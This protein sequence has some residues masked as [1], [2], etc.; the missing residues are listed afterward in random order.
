MRRWESRNYY[1][2]STEWSEQEYTDLPLALWQSQRW[3]QRGSWRC[4]W[5]HGPVSRDN[6]RATFH[7]A[8]SKSLSSGPW[9]SWPTFLAPFDLKLAL[10]GTSKGP[11]VS[12][13]QSKSNM[14]SEESADLTKEKRWSLVWRQKTHGVTELVHFCHESSKLFI[15]SVSICWA[16]T[17][18]M[19]KR[20]QLLKLLSDWGFEAQRV[21]YSSPSCLNFWS[22]IIVK[23]YDYSYAAV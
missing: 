11:A 4:P 15:Y 5:R 12:I 2:Q 16:L 18:S 22:P 23:K 8:S 9:V 1:Y 17:V 14:E 3:K 6:L 21:F 20:T 10:G 13:F 19:E 7:S